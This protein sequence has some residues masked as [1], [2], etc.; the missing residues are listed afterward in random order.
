MAGEWQ[1]WDYP[2][3][4]GMAATLFRRE[5]LER[6]TFRWEPGK[7]ECRCCCDDL[8][9]AGFGIG[10]LAR[11]AQAWHRPVHRRD[12]LAFHPL[13]RQRAGVRHLPRLPS[14]EGRGEGTARRVAVNEASHPGVR[15]PRLQPAAES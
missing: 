10:Y 15:S 9:R 14:G 1:N 13:P 12:E 11:R 5:R 8:R 2:R 3:H 4:V 7:C 6:L